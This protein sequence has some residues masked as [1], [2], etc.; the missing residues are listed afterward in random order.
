MRSIIAVVVAVGYGII[1]LAALSAA[2]THAAEIFDELYAG[3]YKAVTFRG[4]G[5][6][7]PNFIDENGSG[8]GVRLRKQQRK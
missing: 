3:R 2:R 6:R 1:A 7:D 5:A 8:P 4:R